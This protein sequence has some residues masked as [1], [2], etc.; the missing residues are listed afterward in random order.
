MQYFLRRYGVARFLL[1]CVLVVSP[2]FAVHAATSVDAASDSPIDAGIT[3]VDN[4][5]YAEAFTLFSRLAE[6][7][8]AEA[9]YNLA[10]LYRTGKGVKKDMGASFKWF[11][12]A[13]EQG[14]S[15]AQYYLAHMYDNG[16]SVEKSLPKAFE[17]YKKAAEQGQGLAQ[18]NLGVIY[19]DGIGVPQNIE[20]AYLWFHVAAAQGYRA[21]FENRLVIETALKEQG[22]EGVAMLEA[23]KKQA[24]GYFLQYVQPFAPKPRPSRAGREPPPGH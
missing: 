7:G 10:M 23:L 24:R 12:R 15:D 21:A 4:E 9:Q 17:W 16:E 22:E 8:N 1:G 14:I 2:I 19:A 6:E 20:Q 11:Q 18:I 3:A 13:A 5:D